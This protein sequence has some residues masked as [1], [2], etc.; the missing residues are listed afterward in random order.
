VSDFATRLHAV[1]ELVT[2]CAGTLS[3]GSPRLAETSSLL[4]GAFDGSTSPRAE[5]A[6]TSLA[7]ARQALADAVRLVADAGE[8]LDAYLAGVL[9]SAG[10]A[11]PPGAGEAPSRHRDLTEPSRARR[12]LVPHR[13]VFPRPRRER[14]RTSSW[15]WSTRTALR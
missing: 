3:A 10:G 12:T 14:P 11:P 1:R 6:L 15:R 7:D 13:R 8:H 9:G 2:R 5:Q 4:T